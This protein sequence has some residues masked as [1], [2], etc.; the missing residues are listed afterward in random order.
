VDKIKIFRFKHGVLYRGDHTEKKK[1]SCKTVTISNNRNNNRPNGHKAMSRMSG[2]YCAMYTDELCKFQFSI[3]FTEKGFHIMS[4]GNALN[5]GH[6]QVKKVS[7]IFTA[8]IIDENKM[9]KINV[10][11]RAQCGVGSLKN[12][13]HEETGVSFSRQ[14]C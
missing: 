12:V 10:M 7:S 3:S 11:N 1:I 2:T 6:I 5:D 14:Q 8:K 9:E 4:K 13:I